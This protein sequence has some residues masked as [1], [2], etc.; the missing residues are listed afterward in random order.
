MIY[1]NRTINF[2]H[3]KAFGFDM[4]HTL[5]TYHTKAFEKLSFDKIK[6]KLVNEYHY[7]AEIKKLKFTF[8]NAI[9]GL[10]I[11]KQRGNILKISNYG[12]IKSG[13]HGTTKLDYHILQETYRG[14]IAD[15]NDDNFRCVDTAFSIAHAVIY[16]LLV[17][18]KD[19]KLSKLLPD[20]EQIE[21]DVMDALDL[22]HRDGSLKTEVSKNVKKYIKQDPEVVH[23]LER[24]KK[25]GKKIWII[26]NSD[27]A[28][29]KILLDF[30]ILPF[31]KNHEHWTDLFEIVITLSSK[32]RFFSERLPF[33]SVDTE[34]GLMSNADFPILK[35]VYQGGCASKLEKD[36]GLKPNEILYFG[37]HI[38]GDI[39]A[40]K[41][42]SNW[43][44]AFI[45]EELEQELISIEKT[46]TISKNIVKLM[47]TKSKIEVNI[48]KKT[49]K[50]IDNH[51]TYKKI[52]ISKELAEIRKIDQQLSEHIKNHHKYFNKTWGEIMR[53]GG[54]PSR[55]AGQ[56]EKYACIYLARV[57]NLIDYSPKAYFRPIYKKMS[58]EA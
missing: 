16:A 43:R 17:D 6:E 47:N 21:S 53:S 51:Q 42:N 48:D 4:D 27:Y 9:R 34:T 35:G 41:K 22:A 55:F 31:L 3:I 44:T 19:G 46:K 12:I 40:V 26:T 58:H 10:V 23:S 54:E 8:S 37:D 14:Q 2:R 52:D 13:A 57:S 36:Q 11:D 45:C 56:V 33:L 24:F 49:I 18:L 28:Y 20:Y 32:P 29:S 15:L 39:L 5:V 38:F 25:A 7:P 50:A 30:A 1:C